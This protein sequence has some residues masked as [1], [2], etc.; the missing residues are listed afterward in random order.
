MCAGFGLSGRATK[1]VDATRDAKVWVWFA[2]QSTA[3]LCRAMIRH[4]LHRVWFV[5]HIYAV[6]RRDVRRKALPCFGV[7]F[8]EHCMTLQ[9]RTLPSNAGHR[10][11]LGF[12]SHRFAGLRK[13][14]Y[15]EGFNLICT[16][17]RRRA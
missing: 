11:G 12:A 3:C 1:C 6:S 4:A 7:R 5:S 17:M 15:C 14:K 9:S 8:A 16:A 2:A 10:R 13:A